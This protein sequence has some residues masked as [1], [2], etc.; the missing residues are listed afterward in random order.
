[1]LVEHAAG[2]LLD[3]M[4]TGPPVVLV[5]RAF[6]TGR[7]PDAVAIAVLDLWRTEQRVPVVPVVTV[8]GAEINVPP[9]CRLLDQSIGRLQRNG[10]SGISHIC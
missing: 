8:L 10:A 9:N 4:T 1:M 7:A 3:E 6:L 5:S 2:V